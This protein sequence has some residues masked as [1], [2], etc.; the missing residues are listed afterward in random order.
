MRCTLGKTLNRVVTTE[1]QIDAAI[2]RDRLH[3]GPRV[4]EARYDEASDEV[5]IRFENGAR[6]AFPRHLLEGLSAAAR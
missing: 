4:I 1:S 3:A 2:A 6:M 5:A